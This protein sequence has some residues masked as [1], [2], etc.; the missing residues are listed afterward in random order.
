[1]SSLASRV[2]QKRA[3]L[4]AGR[5][6]KEKEKEEKGGGGEKEE[7]KKKAVALSTLTFRKPISMRQSRRVSPSLRIPR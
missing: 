5:E 3:V 6:E 4:F 1:M 2:G 7:K